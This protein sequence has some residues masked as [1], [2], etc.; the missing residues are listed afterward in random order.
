MQPAS[1][2]SARSLII[3]EGRIGRHGREQQ[4]LGSLR[5][6]SSLLRTLHTVFVR[7]LQLIAVFFYVLFLPLIAL[8][9]GSQEGSY[10][11]SSRE[12]VFGRGM[13]KIDAPSR[14]DVAK[15]ASYCC[16][17]KVFSVPLLW[18]SAGLSHYSG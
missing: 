12:Q 18:V 2:V 8:L 4:F 15:Q 7:L 5:I 11:E 17:S 10:S 9:L 16:M 13:V 3:V 14:S 6:M 1:V